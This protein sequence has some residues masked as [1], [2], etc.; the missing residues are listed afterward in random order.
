MAILVAGCVKKDP[1]AWLQD[2][3]KVQSEIAALEG[4]QKGQ[5]KNFDQ[6]RAQSRILE[7]RFVQNEINQAA[8][9]MQIG[10]LKS[11]IVDLKESIEMSKRPVS[12]RR[13]PVVK[14]SKQPDKVVATV[15]TPPVIKTAPEPK[16][17]GEEIRAEEVSYKKA[18]MTLKSGH[19][20]E[21]ND[22]FKQFL[23]S[24]PEG[25]LA[26]R[27]YYWLGESYF[28]QG[29]LTKAEEAFKSVINKFPKS[30]RHAAALLKLGLTYKELGH[31]GDART[32]FRK[33]NTLHPESPESEIAR[34]YLKAMK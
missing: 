12:S 24:Y 1:D 32:S 4:V 16:A 10:S 7:K 11:L 28:T 13:K 31:T 34:E 26:D 21:A 20:E 30:S 15:K 19:Y 27:A 6:L 9:E 22:A 14:P 29:K 8:L 17:I 18:F 25:R 3:G 33:L 2:R 23:G 5:V